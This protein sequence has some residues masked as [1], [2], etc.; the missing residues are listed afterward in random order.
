MDKFKDKVI[1]E[2]SKATGLKKENITVEIPPDSNM[3]DFAFPC[4]VL[5]KEM[6][7]SPVEIAKELASKVKTGGVI[8]EAR[9]IGP[10]LNFFINNEDLSDTIIT[11]VLKEK[12]DYG[13][14]KKTHKV[15]LV[16]FFHANTHKGIHI[17]HIRNISYGSAIANILEFH[18]DNIK[19]VNYEGDIGPHVAKC[20]WGYLNLGEKPPKT[21]K[22]EWLGKIYAKANSKEKEDEKVKEEV[23]EINKK[24]YAGDKKLTELWKKTRQWCLDDFDKFYKDFGVKYDRFYFESEVEK[25]GAEIAK[26][27]LKK[28]IAKESEGA[29]I[30]DLNEYGLGVYV[31]LTKEGNPVYH[32][33]DL[34][35]AE[36]KTKEYKIDESLHVVGKEQEL[37]FK[38]LF[39][40]F[41][42]INSPLAGKSKH[43]IYELV[44]LPEGKMSSREGNV[45]LYNDLIAKL[46]ELST[47]EV[48]KRHPDWSK[49]DVEKAVHDISFG[50]L[51]FG[52]I[53]KE[54]NRK[55]IF[56]W[57]SVLD[58]EGDTGPYIQYSHARI[59]SLL[60][61]V[62]TK[63]K[64]A[65]YS[66]LEKPVERKVVKLLGDYPDVIARSAQ[67]YK[68]HI[69]A[70]YLLELGHA[71]NEF[72][73]ECQILKEEKDLMNARIML[74]M[75]VREVL[76]SG[77][78]VLGI[79]APERM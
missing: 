62:K 8:K 70:N 48:V 4:F 68:T 3:G 13:K 23:K 32:T 15:V 1:E 39:K 11:K 9:A 6:K 30:V 20:L 24:I 64:S 60:A 51:K 78:N 38:Q 33:K 36:L 61:K 27:L 47:A 42:L 25:R 59:C 45:I 54:S 16:E 58:F 67:E 21:G 29:L 46:K 10:Y 31:L 44:M 12:E 7:K 26:E 69:I 2:V 57:D 49:K 5:A 73:H 77:L 18:G 22:E 55:I 56:D 40:T 52:M 41:E 79:N 43:L 50:A 74:V 35:L 66:L 34:G 65:D 76:K 75:A 72:Y 28:G 14:G 19:R 37:Y 53:C 63:P 71:F 17:G